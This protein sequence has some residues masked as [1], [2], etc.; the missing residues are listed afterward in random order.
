MTAQRKPIS[1]PTQRAPAKPYAIKRMSDAECLEL[2]E[3][4][5]AEFGNAYGM[6]VLDEVIEAMKRRVGP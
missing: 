5:R 3:K 6:R 4:V 2:M 1:F